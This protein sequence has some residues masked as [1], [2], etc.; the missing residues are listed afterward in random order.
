LHPDWH[1]RYT[2]RNFVPVL[3]VCKG[4]FHLP[5][6]ISI[7]LGYCL[8]CINPAYLIGKQK[9]YDLKR[10]GSRNAGASN[11]AVILG[12]RWGV[13][14]ALLDIA[15][16]FAAARI[17]QILFPDMTYAAVCAGTACILGHMYPATM[18]FRGGKG[19]AALGGTMLALDWRLFAVVFITGVVLLLIIHYIAII[20]VWTAFIVPAA[21][22]FYYHD[23]ISAMILF[24]CV[25]FIFYKHLENFRR[26]AQGQELRIDWLWKKNKA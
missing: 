16:A 13:L 19:L 14:V 18:R 9:G 21:L 7:A 23:A 17:S 25:P 3:V 8:G 10:E 4:G 20:T 26:I 15:K 2:E 6:L 24:I 1:T 12:F 11:A 5:Y 22:L